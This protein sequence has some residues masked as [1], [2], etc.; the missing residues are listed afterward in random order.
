MQNNIMRFGDLY[1][2][3]K[4]GTVMG[5]PPAPDW[6]NLFEGLHELEFLPRFQTNL[7]LYRRFIDDVFLVWRPTN[8]WLAFALL[9]HWT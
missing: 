8:D 3:Q 9:L 6:A 5:S 7:Q 4:S 2:K 1:V